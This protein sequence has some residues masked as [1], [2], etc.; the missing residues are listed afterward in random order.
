MYDHH[1]GAVGLL[2]CRQPNELYNRRV[3]TTCCRVL[4]ESDMNVISHKKST[5]PNDKWSVVMPEVDTNDALGSNLLVGA[6]A[7]GSFTEGGG[8]RAAVL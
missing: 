6:G 8:R 4:F 3:C 2:A 7:D 1:V 5:P